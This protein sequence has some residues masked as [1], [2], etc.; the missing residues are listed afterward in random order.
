[1]QHKMTVICIV[2]LSVLILALTLT[3]CNSTPGIVGRWTLQNRGGEVEFFKDGT[4]T[5]GFLPGKWQMLDDGRIR[6]TIGL[7]NTYTITREGDVWT[8]TGPGLG[9]QPDVYI[10]RRIK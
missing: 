4:L 8:L 3:A 6:L 1:M 2:T 9:G 10:L 7:S 5:M